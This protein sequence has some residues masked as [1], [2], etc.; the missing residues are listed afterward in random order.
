MAGPVE[1]L[2]ARLEAVETALQEL[3]TRYEQQNQH[4]MQALDYFEGSRK[5]SEKVREYGGEG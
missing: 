4:I 1:E 3:L 5:V 2:L